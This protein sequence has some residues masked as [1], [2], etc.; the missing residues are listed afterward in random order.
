MNK[1]NERVGF[2]SLP[3]LAVGAASPLSH[4]GNEGKGLLPPSPFW[5]GLLKQALTEQRLR[6]RG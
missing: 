3:S 6:S 5:L 4:T 2:A 1:S